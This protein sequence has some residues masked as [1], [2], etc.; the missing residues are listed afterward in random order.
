M[1]VCSTWDRSPGLID[2]QV[3]YPLVSALLSAPHVK[4][5]RAMSD[6]GASFVYVI[7]DDDM[8]PISTGRGR[9]PSSIYPSTSRN[10][11]TGHAIQ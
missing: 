8:I 9:V 11:V 6:L 3:T 4:S 10:Q 7:F 5:V 2:A 1:I